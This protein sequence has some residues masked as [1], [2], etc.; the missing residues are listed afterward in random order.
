MYT[1]VFGDGKLKTGCGG[2]FFLLVWRALSAKPEGKKRMDGVAAASAAFPWAGMM[3]PL[4][5]SGKANGSLSYV[6]GGG[7]LNPLTGCAT[8]HSLKCNKRRMLSRPA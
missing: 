1:L 7:R 5:G 2:S 8:F 4:R 3:P 6:L